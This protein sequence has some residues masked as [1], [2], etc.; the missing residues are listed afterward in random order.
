VLTASNAKSI[1]AGNVKI[2]VSNPLAVTATVT[3]RSETEAV[4]GWTPLSA[5]GVDGYRV[6]LKMAD[7]ST[8]TTYVNSDATSTTISGLAAGSIFTARVRALQSNTS[9]PG[10]TS[11]PSTLGWTPFG[12]INADSVNVVP[13]E[14][15]KPSGI[16]GGTFSENFSIVWSFYWN[17]GFTPVW[18][19]VPSKDQK[20]D[21]YFNTAMNRAYQN[22]NGL[23]WGDTGSRDDVVQL[24]SNGV[25]KFIVGTYR[26]RVHLWDRLPNDPNA[27]AHSREIGLG[28][29][30]QS[31][32]SGAAGVCYDAS[33][34]KL[35]LNLA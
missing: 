30:N 10:D 17:P 22:T 3:P 6:E 11:D 34:N 18:K 27:I 13:Q 32:F 7:G 19:G 29:T 28:S 26:G 23:L 2:R 12:A 14:P 1:Y 9:D 15:W 16:E 35:Q 31:T 5:S 20:G 33:V 24:W 25:D 8:Q 4:V 21:F